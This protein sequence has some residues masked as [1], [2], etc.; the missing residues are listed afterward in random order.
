MKL[1]EKAKKILADD[2]TEEEIAIINSK[3]DDLFFQ[4]NGEDLISPSKAA[5]IVGE[6]EFL[7]G[8]ARAAL[9]SNAARYAADKRN[10]VMFFDSKVHKKPD[11]NADKISR[12][13]IYRS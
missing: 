2:Y 10:W 7:S 1:S 6:R 11:K 5:K 12:N 4:Y 8:V 13:K 3:I 9:H